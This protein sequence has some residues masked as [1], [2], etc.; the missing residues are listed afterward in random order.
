[1][2]Q[3][4]PPISLDEVNINK[5]ILPNTIIGPLN[6]TLITG[7]FHSINIVP[8]QPSI[9]QQG[10][11]L[12]LTISGNNVDFSAP[13]VAT[14]N[15]TTISST[16]TEVINFN[17]YGSLDTAHQ[18]LTINYIQVNVKPLNSSK[19]GVNIL[20]SEKY[21][22]THDEGG[23]IVPVIKFSYPIGSG[24][25]LQSDGYGIVRDSSN[26]FSAKDISNYLVIFSPSSVAGF[27]IIDAVSADR[28]SLTI[29]STSNSFNLPLTSFTSGIYQILNTT[30]YRSGLQNG[31]FTLET[32]GYFT[33]PYFLTQGFYQLEYETYTR[34]KFDPVNE[35][36]F[37]GS[38]FFGNYQINSIMDQVKLY[39]V[40]LTDT[41]IGE[42]IPSNQNSI[43]KDFNSLKALKSDSTTLMLISF[44]SFP[45]TNSADFYI[46]PS[47]D[48]H[49]FQSSAVVNENFGNSLVILDDPLTIEN[50]GILD[51]TKQGSV[52]FWVSPL[53]DTG[54]DPN[55]RYYFD[56]YGAIVEETVSINNI[57][58]K[59]SAPAGQILRV[60]VADGDPRIDYFVGG[61]IETDTQRAIQ[62]ESISINNS[63]A[64]TAKTILQVITVKI[65]G[66][67]TGTDYFADGSIGSDQ[68]TI[69]LGKTL[70]VNNIPLVIT[71]QPAQNNND[72]LNTQVIR[73]N[74]KLPFQNTKV[75]VEY[76]P[77]GLQGDRLSIY[78]DNFGFINFEIFASG[79]SY[80][81]RG[82][83]L[84]SK[85]T[86]HRVKTSYKLNG[87]NNTDEL[88]LW[89]DGYEYTNLHFGDGGIFGSIPA[90]MGGVMA[91]DG[92]AF[93]TNIIFKDPINELFIGTQ[94]TKQNP[95]FSLIDNF[96]ISN[97]S[98]PIYAPYG[99]PLDVNYNSNISMAF[100]VTSDLYTTYLLDFNSLV[101]LNTDFVVLN[102]KNGNSF[103]FSVNIFDSFGIVS[104]SAKVQ[105][106]LETL[107]KT[108]KPA[109]S[110]VLIEYSK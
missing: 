100:P 105:E 66:D 25:N 18:Y 86:W 7:V 65:A 10:R 78:K 81:V 43:T 92:Y 63:I 60:V 27:Y 110:R 22:I 90:L 52:E 107:I 61:K 17:E 99:E 79:Q 84:W 91:G 95:I 96:R 30:D 26:L 55:Y 85:N 77:K 47:T 33:Q 32:D 83:T 80:L 44:D 57:S 103:D 15:G 5:I 4:P 48:K 35:D 101:Q 88:R 39:S 68:K 108:L 23:N 14:I 56:A 1:M 12:S 71:Y 28:K 64:T 104:G 20:V 16:I 69:Y 3:L 34:I 24:Y 50:D 94:Y 13:V 59:L 6:S 109:N 49:H 58:L 21:S 2:T 76:L 72:T 8:S 9:S 46:S 93:T 29:S 102:N 51:T 82:P 70:P 31:F 97:I 40:M 54:N 106:I 45:F 38:D 42:S 53:F 87:G 41:R 37:L 74:K 73:L 98:R 89:L 75:R 11:T 62:E 67:F 36:L 19:S